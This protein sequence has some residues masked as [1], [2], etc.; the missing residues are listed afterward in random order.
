MARAK[1]KRGY[2]WRSG[3]IH[4]RDPV[5]G[6]R[7]STGYSDPQ[8][9]YSWRA[10]R[11]RLAANPSYAASLEATVGRWVVKTLEYKAAQRSAGTLNMYTVKLGHFTRLFGEHAPMSNITPGAVDDYITTRRN[12]GA[13][14]NTI[15]RE[16]TCLRQMLR[17]A[18]R[19]R[20][21]AGDLD[22]IMPVGFSADYK[23]VNR[24]L[25]MADFEKLWLALPS[26]NERAWVALALS[27]G[28]DHSDI[29]RARRFLRHKSDTMARLVYTP[30]QGHELGKLL[31][32]ASS[33]LASQPA[34]VLKGSNGSPKKHARPL[35]G[36]A[37]AEDLKGASADSE[38]E[39]SRE[40]SD[41]PPSRSVTERR[42]L[43][44]TDP[45]VGT[46][47][48]QPTSAQAYSD[49]GSYKRPISNGAAA[50]SLAF[51]AERVLG[52]AL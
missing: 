33:T 40:D 35:G 32:P 5:T 13:K 50:W 45:I 24:L 14:N 25:N 7:T 21:F 46:F 23:P 47:P 31:L 29:E 38:S 12:E 8:A 42:E 2:W 10:E 36:M 39:Q 17:L 34:P 49:E 28:A 22:E 48:S 43:N 19:A 16:L 18:K 9:A 26:D 44:A 37:D 4:T 15:A 30:M 1:L 20:Q 41:E 6:R 51:A 11:E 52:G 27:T 3:H